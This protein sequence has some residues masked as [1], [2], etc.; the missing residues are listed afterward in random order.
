MKIVYTKTYMI[1]GQIDII[2]QY[3]VVVEDKKF[4]QYCEDN[5]INESLQSLLQDLMPIDFKK[6]YFNNSVSFKLISANELDDSYGNTTKE[7]LDETID[8]I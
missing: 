4:K 5:D 8:I 7:L 1:Q 6:K 2:D 3:T